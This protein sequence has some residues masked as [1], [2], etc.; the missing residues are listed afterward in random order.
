M[1]G[2]LNGLKDMIY[3]TTTFEAEDVNLYD[4][5]DGFQVFTFN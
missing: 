5:K 2:R 4:K 3:G 1:F